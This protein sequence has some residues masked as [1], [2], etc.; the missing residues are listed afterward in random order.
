MSKSKLITGIIIIVAGGILIPSGFFV[1][2]MFVDQIA[3]GVPD[4]LLAVEEEALPSLEEQL[5]PLATPDVLLGI[6]EQALDSLEEQLPVLGAPDVLLGIEEQAL[7]TLEEQLPVLGTPDVLLGIEEQALGTLEEQLPVLGTPDVLLGIEEQALGTLE[8]QLPVLATPT[9]LSTLKGTALGALTAIINGSGAAKL[10]N[11]TITAV[12]GSIGYP[13]AKG[14]FFNSSTFQAD[15]LTPMLG[16]SDYYDTLAGDN[17]NVNLGYTVTAQNNLLYGVGPLPGLITDLELGMG[18][19]GYMELYVNVSLGDQTLNATMQSLYDA[20]W[21]QLEALAGYIKDYLWDVVVKSSYSPPYTIEQAAELMF[22]EQ[23]ANGT[24]VEGGIDI[25]LFKDTL[26]PGTLGL[27]AGVPNPTN[28]TSTT[29]V[30]L[31]NVLMPYSFTNDNGILIWIGAMQGNVTLQGYLIGAFSLTGA[32]LTILL[33]WLGNFMAT[34]VPLLLF[35]ETGY[36]VPELAQFAFYE[37]WANG[38]IQGQS[39]LPDGFLNEISAA[40]S[41]SPYFEV[42]I[43]IPSNLSLTKTMNLW[44]EGNADAFVN[45]NGILVWVGAMQGNV[46]L[47]GYLIGVFS[48]TP[49]NL[50]ILLT[51]LGNFMTV[52]VPQLMELQTGYTIPELAQLG[53]YEQWAN[54]TIQGQSILPDGFLN[55]VSAAFAGAPYFEVGIPIPSNLSLTKTM[56]LWDEAN[57]YAF[58]N[59]SGILVWVGAMQGDVTLQGYLI[60]AFSLTPGNLTILLTWLGNFMTVRVPQLMELQ[61]GYTIPELAQLGFYEQWASGTIQG[62]SILP[63]GFLNEVSAAFAGAPYFEV[64]LP[65]PSGLSPTETENLW[66]EA[67]A[68]AF[69]NT[70]GILVWVG[71]MQGDLI[72]QGNLSVAFGIS[73]GELAVLLTWLG[74]FLTVRV[75]QLIEYE[76]GYTIPELA[77]LGFYEQWANGTIQ[78]QSILP[79]GFL[80]EISAAFAGKPYFEVGLP[81]PSNLSLADTMSLWNETNAYAFVNM[82]GILVWLEAITNTSLQST[83]ITTFGISAGELT[84]L[85]TWLGNFFTTRVPQLIEYETG[86]TVPELAQLAFYEQWANGT[87]QGLSILPDGFLSE[88]DP[89]ILGPP[90]FE[91]GLTEGKTRL[92]ASQCAA[93][94][95]ETSEYSLVNASG[96]NKWYS[97]KKWYE[98]PTSTTY[99]DLKTYNGGLSNAQMTQILDWLPQF[100]DEIVNTLA[101]EELGLPMEPYDLGNTLLISLGAGGGALAAVGVVLLIL[102]KRK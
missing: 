34:L 66:N 95:N 6:E 92:K 99:E 30:E 5:P 11:V 42:G 74:N 16:V 86:H 25:S 31:W 56:N 4:A 9:I 47:Q 61:T 85:L 84:V 51:W 24:V 63:D 53:F 49:G 21:P 76:T 18:V 81:S 77:Q 79:D 60:G 29:C 80:S 28:I 23:W 36:T 14:Q 68:Y 93:L 43:P 62:Q 75:P 55:E 40:F 78:G 88:L 37:Q 19:L 15:Y 59:T 41:G 39:I 90:Y 89:P 65:S 73:A 54:G 101:K 57:A 46:T 48:L 10:I 33:G 70:T 67:S 27:E 50:T 26:P 44:D 83:L 82:D 45:M 13:A 71:A 96:I 32:Q 91:V 97:V 64:G 7:G 52:R 1:N 35:D 94:W 58:V 100:R 69:V 8:G 72:L 20:T 38:T 3:D 2:Q 22:Y 102:S 12:A 98:E 87:I 17:D